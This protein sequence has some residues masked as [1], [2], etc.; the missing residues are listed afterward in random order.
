[1]WMA[2]QLKNVINY[3]NIYLFKQCSTCFQICK[4]FISLQTIIYCHYFVLKTNENMYIQKCYK[5]LM[6]RLQFN[7]IKFL[8]FLTCFYLNKFK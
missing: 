5:K 6:T 7:P 3:T 2:H 1:M 8:L 4:L